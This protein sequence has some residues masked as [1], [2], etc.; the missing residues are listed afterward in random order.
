MQRLDALAY[1]VLYRRSLPLAEDPSGEF[2][3]FLKR[4][5]LLHSGKVKHSS[6]L[7]KGKKR[8]EKGFK[9]VSPDLRTYWGMI[10]PGACTL[11]VFTAVNNSARNKLGVSLFLS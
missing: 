1:C 8:Q 9:I 11:K 5:V 4:V 6:L 2:T 7:Y 10:I 3:S